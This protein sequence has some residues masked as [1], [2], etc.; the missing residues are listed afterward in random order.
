MQLKILVR[1]SPERH[2]LKWVSGGPENRLVVVTRHGRDVERKWR[3]EGEGVGGGGGSSD[4]LS[5]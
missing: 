5:R 3:E 2:L 4:Y 1:V